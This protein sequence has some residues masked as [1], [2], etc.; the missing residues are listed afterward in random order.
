[1]AATIYDLNREQ[2]RSIK[3]KSA[4]LYDV[5]KT[6]A[7]KTDEEPLQDNEAIILDVEKIRSRRQYINKQERYKSFVE[8]CTDKVLHI[9]PYEKDGLYSYFF[10]VKED[11][12]EVKWL[13]TVDDIKERNVNESREQ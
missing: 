13:F 4:E 12:N 5:L 3:K 11:I 1:M 10:S 8:S 7:G 6:L 9:E 2:R